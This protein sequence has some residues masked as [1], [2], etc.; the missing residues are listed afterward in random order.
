MWEGGVRGERWSGRGRVDWCQGERGVVGEG[1]DAFPI[2]LL[3]PG[4]MLKGVKGGIPA[5]SDLG[6]GLVALK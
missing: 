1:G 4:T 5:R 3:G 2:R 6:F